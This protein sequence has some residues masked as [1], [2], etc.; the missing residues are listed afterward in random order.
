MSTILAIFIGGGL[1]SLARFLV[2]SKITSGFKEINPLGTM[3]ANI[4]STIIL[5]VV[6]YLATRNNGLTGEGGLSDSMKALIITGFC[7]GFSTFSTFSYETFELMRSNQYG[8]ATI[9]IVVSVA[10]GVG[11][12]FILSKS[13]SS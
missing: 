1:G 5:G 4:I 6:L 12:L 8:Y 9:N 3:T 7:G 10:L 2:S 13:L 11:V